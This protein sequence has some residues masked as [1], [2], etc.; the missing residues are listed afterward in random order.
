MKRI[1]PECPEC[2]SIDVIPIIYGPPSKDLLEAEASGLCIVGGQNMSHTD[3]EWHCNDCEHE[4][5]EQYYD[6]EEA[7]QSID[8]RP[9]RR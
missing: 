8:T 9:A 2:G 7:A 5:S 4:W 6:K 3:P 1:A